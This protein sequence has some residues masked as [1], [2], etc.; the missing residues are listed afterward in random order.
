[1]KI[2]KR[3]LFALHS[4]L[5]LIAGIFILAICLSGAFVA[6]IH[7]YENSFEGEKLIVK[8]K[9]IR[10]PYDTLFAIAKKEIPDFQLYDYARFPQQSDET[11]ELLYF[12]DGSYHSVFIDPYTGDVKGKMALNLSKWLLKFHW[13]FFIGSQGW[14]GSIIVFCFA[15]CLLVSIITGFFIYKKHLLDS[16]FF[17]T[18]INWKTFKSASSGLHRIIGAWTMLFLFIVFSSGAFINYHILN[19]DWSY[20]GGNALN[21]LPKQPLQISVDN[22]IQKAKDTIP[23]FNPTGFSFPQLMGGDLSVSG[24]IREQNEFYLSG[25]SVSFN[26]TTGQITEI[27][28]GTENTTFSKFENIIYSLHYANYGGLFV[29]IIYCTLA[30]LSGLMPITGFI[31]WRRRTRHERNKNGI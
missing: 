26:P 4:W 28:N 17:R 23:N 19:G 12:P 14:L 20:P 8:P 21:Q 31:L 18:K 7:Q 3:K 22:C 2:T 10:L 1:L 25:S 15:I 24:L 9:A 5:G 29:K 11:L 6:L 27:S 16:F 13:S 30:L